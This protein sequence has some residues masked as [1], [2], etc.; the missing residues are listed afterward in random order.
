MSNWV[1]HHESESFRIFPKN[2][3]GETV[4][5][6]IWRRHLILRHKSGASMPPPY[7]GFLV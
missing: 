1:T 4:P 6:T 2:R 7:P 3:K 5:V